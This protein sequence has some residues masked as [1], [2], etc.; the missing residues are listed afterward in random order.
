[1]TTGPART[2]DLRV[3]GIRTVPREAGPAS[4][5]Q[6]ALSYS[7]QPR[8][9]APTGPACQHERAACAG[10]SPGTPRL[11]GTPASHA[12][13]AP[14]PTARGRISRALDPPGTGQAHVVAPD[15]GGPPGLQW[16]ATCPGR[17]TSA[18]LINTCVLP[19]YRW[20]ALARIGEPRRGRASHGSHHPGRL[21]HPCRGTATRAGRPRSSPTGCTTTPTATPGRRCCGRTGPPTPPHQPRSSPRRCAHSKQAC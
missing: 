14:P 17:F 12:T 15:F 19:G 7:R 9:P 16:S 3:A 1:V 2:R 20:H 11:R 4:D 6:A 13:P 18:G 8:D 10:P 21:P 5:R